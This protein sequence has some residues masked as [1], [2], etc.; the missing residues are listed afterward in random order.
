MGLIEWAA[1]YNTTSENHRCDDAQEWIAVSYPWICTVE[2]THHAC[3]GSSLFIYVSSPSLSVC[4]VVLRCVQLSRERRVCQWQCRARVCV[5]GVQVCVICMS[6]ACGT[7]VS[8]E[9]HEDLKT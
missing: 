1:R 5:N 2:E 4:C 8:R 7:T 3:G 9:T 6:A